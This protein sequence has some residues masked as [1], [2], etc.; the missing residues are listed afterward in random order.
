MIVEWEHLH[1]DRNNF[2]EYDNIAAV[3][4]GYSPETFTPIKTRNI[5]L[6]Q[7]ID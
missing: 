7:K 5:L 1:F 4:D 6:S 3:E 2:A